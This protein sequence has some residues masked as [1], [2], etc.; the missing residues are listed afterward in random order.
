MTDQ[1]KIQTGTWWLTQLTH[2]LHQFATTPTD[3]NRALLGEITKQY[4]DAARSGSIETPRIL[5]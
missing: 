1:R 5:R 2:Y 3:S 4:Q